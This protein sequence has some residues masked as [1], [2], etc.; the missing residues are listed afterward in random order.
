MNYIPWILFFAG[1]IVFIV[2][3]FRSPKR[4]DSNRQMDVEDVMERLKG[5]LR[6]AKEKNVGER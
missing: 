6:K 5:N 2:L 3:G 4:Q 1:L